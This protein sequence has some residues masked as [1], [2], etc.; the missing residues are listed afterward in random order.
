MPERNDDCRMRDEYRQRNDLQR[1]ARTRRRRHRDRRRMRT[2]RC[3]AIRQRDQTATV[4]SA[5]GIGR[6]RN[7]HDG[8]SLRGIV[9]RSERQE[10]CRCAHR[11]CAQRTDPPARPR[12]AAYLLQFVPTLL[13]LCQ[14]GS[15]A[16]RARRRASDARRSTAHSGAHR[17][18]HGRLAPHH[19]IRIASIDDARVPAIAG[20]RIQPRR[21]P[22]FIARPAT[23]ERCPRARTVMFRNTAPA[24]VPER[25]RHGSPATPHRSRRG[26]R[27]WPLRV[28]RRGSRRNGMR[29]A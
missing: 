25:N 20:R 16:R 17:P 1:F 13:H 10:A 15:A 28:A 23:P 4:C 19:A 3:D 8:L 12:E 26:T 6:N 2:G 11:P 18:L 21:T 27:N 22:R 9:S 5:N 14:F 7:I 29:F 24:A